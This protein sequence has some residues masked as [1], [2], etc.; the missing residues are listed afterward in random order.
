MNLPPLGRE[1]PAAQPGFRW[2]SVGVV[3]PNNERIATLQETLVSVVNQDYSGVVNCY[4]VYRS[5]PGILPLLESLGNSIIAVAAADIPSRN[6][7]S[8]KRNIGVSATSEELVAL[9]DDD[10]LW[11]PDKLRIQVECLFRESTAVA[12]GTKYLLFRDSPRWRPLPARPGTCDLHGV[13][14][15]RRGGLVTSS[16]LIH[17][18]VMRDLRFDERPDWM[19]VEDFDLK[20]RLGSIGCVRRVEAHL[21]AM[22]VGNLS[23]SAT[24]RPLQHSRALSVLAAASSTDRRISLR[25][26]ALETMTCAA[27]AGAGAVSD[28]AKTLLSE[29]LDGRLFG[30]GDRVVAALIRAIWRVPFLRTIVRLVH[31]GYGSITEQLSNRS[32]PYPPP[33][34]PG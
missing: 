31:R 32:R 6:P 5:R 25:I 33:P 18:A 28:S 23:T 3:V 9:V 34:D 2:P 10:D 4:L 22:R 17:G 19:G 21:T 30:R 16:L 7:I 15:V 14:G 11:H 13:S 26:A 29:A 20:I 27:F 1:L 8:V 12:V 24:D